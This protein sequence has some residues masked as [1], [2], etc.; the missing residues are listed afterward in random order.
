MLLPFNEKYRVFVV[1]GHH[2]ALGISVHLV[3]K[4]QQCRRRKLCT[5]NRPLLKLDIRSGILLRSTQISGV[6]T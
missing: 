1:R 6:R 4:I 5:H 3:R 2:L